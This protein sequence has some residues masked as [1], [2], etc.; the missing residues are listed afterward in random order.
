MNMPVNTLLNT[1]SDLKMIYNI[2]SFFLSNVYVFIYTEIYLFLRG[3]LFALKIPKRLPV[4]NLSLEW[5]Y[6]SDS[7]DL[8]EH[9]RMLFRACP[10]SH[11]WDTSPPHSILNAK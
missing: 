2:Q 5:L 4:E 11:V 9:F 10:R 6:Y 1:D 3:L 8:Y 7:C